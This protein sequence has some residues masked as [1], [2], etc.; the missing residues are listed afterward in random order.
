M[1]A[2]LVFFG[3]FCLIF[4]Q[5]YH[6]PIVYGNYPDPGVIYVDG[7]YY[8]STTSNDNQ[9]QNIF[10]IHSS[11]TLNEWNLEGYIFNS[12][13]IPKWA[14]G[15]TW[16]PEIHYING[17]YV[18]YFVAR[19]TDGVLCIGAATAPSVT[20][21][22]TDIGQP[23]VNNHTMGMIDPTYYNDNGVGYLIWKEDG[24]GA[25][26]PEKYT[27]IWL[28]PLN[29]DGLSFTDTP[30]MEI[31]HNDP[32]SWEGPLVEAPW[33]IY[34]NN[35]YY[36]FYSANGYAGPAYGVGVA[37]SKSI[38]GPYT[39]WSR[40]PIVHSNQAWSGPGHCSVVQIAGTKDYMMI[41]HSWVAGHILGQWPRVMLMDQV[42][43]TNDQWPYIDMFSPS[44]STLPV[45]SF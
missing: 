29:P 39:K 38:T 45:P 10:A 16:A 31:L 43:W 1:Q 12:S 24:N 41:Y 18:V 21:P 8:A 37:R 11:S 40:N 23:L 22:F 6:N 20:G 19:N 7:V 28:R 5:D 36:L 27:P 17:Q 33:V 35:Y 42:L 13:N 25:N 4:G 9:P 34:E 44:N 32:G 14:I 15:D 26:P 30:K 2:I 3:L